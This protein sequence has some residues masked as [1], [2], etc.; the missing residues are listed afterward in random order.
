MS[1]H[2]FTSKAE[3]LAHKWF[4][5]F[6]DHKMLLLFLSMLC[7]TAS[8]IYFNFR[9]GRLNASASDFTWYVMPLSY[10][11]LDIAL[12]CIG[13]ALF[14]GVI[15]G[16]LKIISWV[17]FFF[18]LALSLFACLSCLIALDAEKA[19]TGDA[20]KRQ[21]LERALATANDSVDTWS[22][23]VALTIKHKS[24][25]QDRLDQAV[26]QRD[27]LIHEISKLDSSTPPAQMIFEKA[28]SF[29]PVWMDGDM[30]KTLSR[31]IFGFA[32]VITPLILTAILSQVLTVLSRNKPTPPN[33]GQREPIPTTDSQ[34][35]D[36]PAGKS[37]TPAET[38]SN[39]APAF[40]SS[41]IAQNT[42]S[43]SDSVQLNRESLDKAREWVKQQTG[44]VQRQQ[45]QYRSGQSKYKQTSLIIAELESEGWIVRLGNGQLKASKPTLR[46]VS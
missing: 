25:F 3:K 23:N 34:S 41:E 40:K 29:L 2:N 38:P 10:S 24:R 46:A 26:Y 36:F 15:R 16:L 35:S 6:N 31:L 37:T 39:L 4:E 27:N 14:A 17:W 42:G 8:S 21:Q 19:S 22:R 18:L 13:M 30:F 1:G 28:E 11:F 9:L 43:L 44:R 5:R 7:L 20:F 33:D 45:I 32:M 12:L